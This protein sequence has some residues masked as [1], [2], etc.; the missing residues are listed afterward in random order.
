MGSSPILH[1]PPQT[2]GVV[3]V[4]GGAVVVV[5]GAVVVV[6][7]AVVV[8]VC[9]GFVVVVRGGF[10]VVVPLFQQNMTWL[11]LS[12]WV[13]TRSSSLVLGLPP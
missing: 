8:V 5:G 2:C 12:G 3:V 1:V 4:V 9:G 6:G 11:M 10:V 7:G 13:E